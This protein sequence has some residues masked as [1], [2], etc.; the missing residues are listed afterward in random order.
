MKPSSLSILLGISELIF[1]R[2]FI[3]LISIYMI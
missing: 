1:S 2:L 3:K